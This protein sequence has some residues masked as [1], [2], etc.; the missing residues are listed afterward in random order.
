MSIDYHRP[1]LLNETIEALHIKPDGV[2]VDVTF[3]GGGHSREIL[4]N[5]NENG[6]LIAFDQDP[7]ARENIP[8]NDPRF[9]LVNQNFKYLTQFLQFH[10]VTK[11]DGILADLGVSSHQ[12]DVAERGFSTRFKGGLDMR[13]NPQ[14]NLTAFDIV[15]EYAEKKIADILYQYGELTAARKIAATIVKNR[16]KSPLKTTQ[17]LTKILLPLLPYKKQ[18]RMLAQ[19]FQ[20][21]RIEVNQEL[22]VLK[23]FLNQVPPLLKENGRLC[24]IS[25]HSLEDRFVKRFMRDGVFSG[26]PEKDFYGNLIT[27]LKPI[28]KFIN[29]SEKEI[30]INKR[31]RSAKLRTAIKK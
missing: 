16:N 14:N 15:N 31:A 11:I 23:D 29:P 13:M 1:V 20:A 6:R 3:G 8:K 10:N 25:Y 4:K 9:L 7:D 24:V 12:F 19:V 28:G 21:L 30:T 2:Y 26:N 27:P 18:Q 5:L 17:D 22:T